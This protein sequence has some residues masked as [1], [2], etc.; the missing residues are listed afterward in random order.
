MK[1][2]LYEDGAPFRETPR[3][4]LLRPARAL[5]ASSSRSNQYSITMAIASRID[6]M[7]VGVTCPSFSTNR[8]TSTPR[9]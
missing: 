8:D 4:P 7:A 3:S 2:R 9:S 5:I 6:L 1:L